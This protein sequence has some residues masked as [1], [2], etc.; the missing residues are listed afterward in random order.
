MI[1]DQ[2]TDALDHAIDTAL[3]ESR[4]VGGVVTVSHNGNTI[5]ERAAGHANRESGVP[6]TSDT[7]VRL[8]SVT[9]PFTSVAALRLIDQGPLTLDDPVVRWL[10]TFAPTL[11][12]GSTAPILVRHLLTHTSGLGYRFFQPPG[13]TYELADISDGLDLPGRALQDNLSRIAA[14]PLHFEPGTSWA[15][16]VGTDV[17]GAVLQSLTGYSLPEVISSQV[18]QPL[19]LVDAGFSVLEPDRLATPYVNDTPEPHVLQPG[20]VVSS[21]DWGEAAG[22]R[23]DPN[24]VFDTTSFASGGGGMVGTARDVMALL[25]A[26]RLDAADG[27]QRLLRPETAASLFTSQ[28][29]DLESG[30]G[31]AF[32]FAGAV[33]TDPVAAETP[34]SAGSLRWGGVYGH[35]WFIDPEKELTVAIITNTIYEGMSGKLTDDVR[36]ALYLAS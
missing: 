18:T 11:P 23:F 32:S 6:F 27:R 30:P 22:V 17:L 2:T 14:V 28:I 21:P 29:G 9:K 1:S 24:R 33:V 31:E 25:E 16:S 3:A 19:G 35:S 7:I 36:N 15:Y 34:L 13:G 12:D 8:A 10:P 5:Y 4:L 26:V 20:E